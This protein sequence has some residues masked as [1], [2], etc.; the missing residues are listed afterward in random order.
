MNSIDYKQIVDDYFVYLDAN[1]DGSLS[2]NE[3]FKFFEF[4]ATKGYVFPVS[5]LEATFNQKDM[6]HDGK[7]TKQECIEFAKA[8]TM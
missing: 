6:D 4:V 8:L 5:K 3:L 1:D 2:K 7:F